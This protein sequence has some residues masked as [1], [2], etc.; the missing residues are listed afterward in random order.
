[1]SQPCFRAVSITVRRMQTPSA[2][3][4][5]WKQPDT[6]RRT[7]TMRR[8]RSASL[9]VK[10]TFRSSRKSRI[11]SLRSAAPFPFRG[12]HQGWQ[13][14]VEPDHPVAAGVEPPLDFGDHPRLYG[15]R[16]P[17]SG[18]IGHRPC[19]RQIRAIPEAQA[20][21]SMSVRAFGS[22]R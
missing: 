6:F 14:L 1:M 19:V 15:T 9:S 18:V 20:S 17:P 12:G 16:I 5:V 10:G 8:F 7:L 4:M 3:A 22:R 11:P 13:G 21:L 2:P